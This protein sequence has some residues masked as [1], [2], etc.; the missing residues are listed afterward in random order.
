MIKA[1][2]EFAMRGPVIDMAVGIIIGGAFGTIVKSLVDRFG[3]AVAVD[4][5]PGRGTKVRVELPI[6]V[7][8]ADPTSGDRPGSTVARRSPDAPAR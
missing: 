5:A 7:S 2:K 6:A 8:I 1:F 4:S 3:G